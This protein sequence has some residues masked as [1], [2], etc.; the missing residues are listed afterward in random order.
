MFQPAALAFFRAKSKKLAWVV[1]IYKH[2]H[3]QTVSRTRAWLQ[4]VVSCLL[5]AV[6]QQPGTSSAMSQL[7]SSSVDVWMWRASFSW[8]SLGLLA[9]SITLVSA[10]L[11]GW[12]RSQAC[13]ATADFSSIP[14]QQ[15]SWC[16]FLLVPS[17]LV[18]S[19]CRSSHSCRG[20]G[21]QS[22]T[23]SLLAVCP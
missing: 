10:H 2:A 9:R 15:A 21:K 7:R 11:M 8:S 17:L 1:S 18:V 6:S 14:L 12:W 23:A 3:N 16:S 4:S 13:S 19:Q 5:R 22:W 20:S